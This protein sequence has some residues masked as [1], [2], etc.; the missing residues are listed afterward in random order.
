MT[1]PDT[2]A[3]LAEIYPS[4]PDTYAPPAPA[5]TRETVAD[6]N[7][8]V[9][10]SYYHEGQRYAAIGATETDARAL[11]NDHPAFCLVR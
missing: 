10:I 3:L 11:L 4:E 5:R 1:N 2:S 9:M 7:G 8:N 6:I